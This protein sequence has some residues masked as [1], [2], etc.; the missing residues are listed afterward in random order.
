MGELGGRGEEVFIG[1]NGDDNIGAS[2]N[3]Q[4]RCGESEDGGVGVE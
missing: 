1:V 3:D 4:Q 2:G